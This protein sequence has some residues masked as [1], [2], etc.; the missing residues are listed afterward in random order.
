MLRL[1]TQSAAYW[2]SS[3]QVTRA[4]VEFLFS[5]FIE[6]ETPLS[7]QELAL[8]LIRHR[9]KQEE[10]RLRKQ[11]DRG[12]I[13]QPNASYEVGK[14]LVFHAM[15]FALGRVVAKREGRNP[16]YG[17]FTVIEV[18]FEDKHRREFASAL[19][20][21]HALILD[22]DGGKASP[23]FEKLDADLIYAEYG[24]ALIEALEARLVDEADAIY[25]SGKWFL[26]SQLAQVNVGQLH[27]AEAVLDMN[28][29]GPLPPSGILKDLD[30]DKKMSP[31]LREF[32]LNVA[33]NNDERF[34]DVGPAGQVLWYLRRLEP[35]EVSKVPPRLVYHPLEYD[36]NSLNDE[37]L[38]LERELDD[39]LSNFEPPASPTDGAQL[40]LIYPHRRVGT[41]PLTS[42]VSSLFPTALESPRIRVILVDGQTGEEFAGW[43]VRDQKY[44]FGLGDFYRRHRL[45]IGALVTVRKTDDPAKLVVDFQAHRPRTE[46]I[47]LAQPTPEGR[48]TFANHKRSI[49]AVYDELLILGA[50]DIDGVDAIWS[51]VREKRRG[52]AEIMR[53]LTP[54]L[55]RLNPQNAVHAKTLYSAVNI[56]R[57]CPPGPIFA[58]LATRPEF[59][60]VGGPYWRLSSER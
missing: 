58:L 44:V 51:L 43:V 54:E 53:D 2:T 52:L 50:D 15:G 17:E 14:E 31:A 42:R 49:G 7:G 26:R 20:Q 35:P 56:V 48:L 8:R 55:A 27:L 25:H 39:E 6:E 29:G 45:P 13:F 40:T 32:S 36:P 12:T 33:M 41:L 11:I 9:L 47:R 3:F 34:D 60:H 4:D 5:Q 21:P 57:R 10:D 46:Y 28:N 37:L 59:H 22:Q 18:E 1:P 38:V 16:E 23:K 24:E 19:T 30:F